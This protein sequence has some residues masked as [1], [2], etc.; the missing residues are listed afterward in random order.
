MFQKINWMADLDSSDWFNGGLWFDNLHK[1]IASIESRDNTF[2]LQDSTFVEDSLICLWQIFPEANIPFASKTFDFVGILDAV[3][4]Y[5]SVEK[6]Y[7]GWCRTVASF[8]PKR[9]Q[10]MTSYLLRAKKPI[11]W[12][13]SI[14]ESSNFL[15]CFRDVFGNTIN[16][17]IFTTVVLVS[18]DNVRIQSDNFFF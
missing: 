3:F 2:V 6:P 4:H 17:Q 9:W 1:T 7:Y 11:S 18:G 8:F 5:F 13:I 15:P 14:Q 16:D 12:T 10:A